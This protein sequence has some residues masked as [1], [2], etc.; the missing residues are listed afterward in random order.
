VI[1]VHILCLDDCLTT[2]IMP[3]PTEITQFIFGQPL[4]ERELAFRLEEA[5]RSRWS[6]PLAIAILGA[7][8]AAAGSAYVSWFN[9]KQNWELENFKAEA[10]RIFEV[11]K[12]P[13]PDLAAQ[14]LQF[15][16]DAGLIQSEVTKQ[17]ISKYL[18]DRSPGQGIVLPTPT[19][20]GSLKPDTLH[21]VQVV[22]RLPTLHLYAM[23]RTR[24]ASRSRSSR[25]D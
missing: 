17:N 1:S 16:L 20:A 19:A 4:R 2:T 12:A 23:P 24:A 11:V 13:S 21:L 14:N 25:V 22:P 15:L 10:T 5:R 18:K 8:I 3:Q 9:G 7:A 6:N